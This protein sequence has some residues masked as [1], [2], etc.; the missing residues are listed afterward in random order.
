MYQ[1]GKMKAEIVRVDDYVV[2]E[3]KAL[4]KSINQVRATADKSW[5]ATQNSLQAKYD[6]KKGEASA[7]GDR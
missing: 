1:N 2:T 7:H 6:M 5:V 4:A 3:T